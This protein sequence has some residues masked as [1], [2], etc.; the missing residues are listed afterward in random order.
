MPHRRQS[1]VDFNSGQFAVGAVQLKQLIPSSD[2]ARVVVQGAAGTGKTTLLK[3]LAYL[4]ATEA[5]LDVEAGARDVACWQQFDLVLH[6]DLSSTAL[7]GASTISGV[8]ASVLDRPASSV[9]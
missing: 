3:R 6:V 9:G 4:W 5:G 8:L 1:S 2:S 7:G